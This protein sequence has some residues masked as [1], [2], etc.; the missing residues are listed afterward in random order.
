M[1]EAPGLGAGVDDVCAVGEAV[2]DG[3]GESGVGEDL[4]PFAE[5]QVGGD[6]QAAAFVAF[7]EDLEDELGGA[8]G[9]REIAQLVEDDELGAGVAADD[10]GE[11]AAAVGFLEFVGEPGEGGEADACGLAWQA[12]TASAVASIVL[13]VPES[14]MKITD[15]RSSIQEPSASAAIVA[16]GTF[17][18]SVEAEVLE[19]FDVREARVDQAASFAAFGAFGDLGLQQRGEVGDRGLLLADG[20]GGERAEAARTVGQ[21]AARARAPRSAPPAP[22]VFARRAHRAASRSSSWS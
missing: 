12:Q 17:G 15:S 20:F 18:L 11:L 10:A 9:Q 19:A 5:G 4:G 3:F 21:L 13:P 8:V 22:A 2:D 1:A 16:C 7:G 6:D 14:P